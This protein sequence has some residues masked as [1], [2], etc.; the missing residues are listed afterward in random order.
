MKIIFS[1]HYE[2][3]KAKHLYLATVNKQ[4][5][6]ELEQ[7]AK[8]INTSQDP[9]Y[10]VIWTHWWRDLQIPERDLT[11]RFKDPHINVTIKLGG[12]KKDIHLLLAA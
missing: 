10:G 2:K 8:R 6:R 4:E 11:T 1:Y 9:Q 5:L 3:G 12:K 7:E